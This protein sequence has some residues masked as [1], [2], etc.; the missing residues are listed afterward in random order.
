MASDGA[1]PVVGVRAAADAAMA[2]EEAVGGA[3]AASWPAPDAGAGSDAA[4]RAPAY[5]RMA[6]RGRAS[7]ARVTLRR[8][9]TAAPAEDAGSWGEPAAGVH[10]APEPSSTCSGPVMPMAALEPP[11]RDAAPRPGDG[12]PRPFTKAGAEDRPPG[13][14]LTWSRGS[15]GEAARCGGEKRKA[16]VNNVAY[17][18]SQKG[19]ARKT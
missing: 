6:S 4:V 11:G 10:A 1:A 19:T 9:S 3:Q 14:A 16:V 17:G 15:R 7:S 18:Q 5:A 8:S 13:I 12:R 2:E